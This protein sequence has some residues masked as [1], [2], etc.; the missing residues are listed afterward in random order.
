MPQL[1]QPVGHG[2]EEEGQ[3]RVVVVLEA[4]PVD[5][6]PRE[7]LAGE[8]DDQDREGQAPPRPGLPGRPG[9]DRHAQPEDHQVARVVGDAG[10]VVGVALLEE[11]DR[12][13][14][15]GPGPPGRRRGMRR[16]QVV[17]VV[18]H[19]DLEVQERLAGVARRVAGEPLVAQGDPRRVADDVDHERHEREAGQGDEPRRAEQRPRDEPSLVGRVGGR[20]RT[21]GRIGRHAGQRAKAA[22]P[23]QREAQVGDGREHEQRRPAEHE[24]AGQ[25]GATGRRRAPAEHDAGQ[26]REAAEDGRRARLRSAPRRASSGSDGRRW[27]RPGRPSGSPSGRGSSHRRSGRWPTSARWPASQAPPSC[28]SWPPAPAG[29]QAPTA[30]ARAG[31]CRPWHRRRP[32]SR[33]APAQAAPRSSGWPGR[34]PIGGATGPGRSARTACRRRR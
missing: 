11:P 15:E 34:R 8:A 4:R 24:V 16:A 12:L 33:P 22:P 19:L 7:P 6:R 32:T 30:A 28:R 13:E 2:G 27:P 23:A 25:G 21:V 1:G 18:V 3:R 29:G 10:G 20:V 17:V 9:H 14:V 5:A 26:D 31:R